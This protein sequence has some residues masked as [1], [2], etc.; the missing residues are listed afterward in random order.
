LAATRELLAEPHPNGTVLAQAL[1]K[2][3]HEHWA[4]DLP[5]LAALGHHH[6]RNIRELAVRLGAPAAAPALSAQLKL[7]GPG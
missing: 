6:R 2:V 4:K 5:E 7:P 3:E 1:K